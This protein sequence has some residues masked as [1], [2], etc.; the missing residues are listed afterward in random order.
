MRKA[1]PDFLGRTNKQIYAISFFF[2]QRILAPFQGYIKVFPSLA[3]FYV[4][5]REKAVELVAELGIGLIFQCTLIHQ[6]YLNTNKLASMVIFDLFKH[7]RPQTAKQTVLLDQLIL[8][9]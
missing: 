9:G 4:R 5:P 8:F 6:G 3:S 1:L 2:Y 7:I